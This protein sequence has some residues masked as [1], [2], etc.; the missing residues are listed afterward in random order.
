MSFKNGGVTLA[1]CFCISNLFL[2]N[3]L[4]NNMIS[5]SF[6]NVFFSKSSFYR[7]RI[8]TIAFKLEWQPD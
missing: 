2:S 3:Y 8:D 6:A 7:E 4:G 5:V 1:V